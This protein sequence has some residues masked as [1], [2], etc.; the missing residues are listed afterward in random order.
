MYINV[1]TRHVTGEKRRFLKS[2]KNN[3]NSESKEVLLFT[4]SALMYKLYAENP[5]RHQILSLYYIIFS[6]VIFYLSV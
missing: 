4:L 6:D 1:V 2:E 5:S 3:K